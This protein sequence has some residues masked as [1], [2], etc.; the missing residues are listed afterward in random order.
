M[1]DKLLAGH[2]SLFIPA[3]GQDCTA[4]MDISQLEDAKIFFVGFYR[5]DSAVVV[6][7]YLVF[8]TSLCITGFTLT[9]ICNRTVLFLF[10]GYGRN[11][12]YIRYQTVFTEYSHIFSCLRVF[13]YLSLCL[14]E[15][16]FI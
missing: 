16:S 3:I 4:Q 8:S 11:I 1:S 14:S 10:A 5:I 2:K 6:I 15:F 9:T 12:F 7:F 13:A